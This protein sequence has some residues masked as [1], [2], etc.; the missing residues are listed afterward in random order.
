MR[1]P[2]SI[3]ASSLWHGCLLTALLSW[4][5]VV[6]IAR[7]DPEEEEEAGPFQAFFKEDPA[8]NA[9]PVIPADEY[10]QVATALTASPEHGYRWDLWALQP[11]GKPI[12]R[13]APSGKLANR[14][15]IELESGETIGFIDCTNAPTTVTLINRYGRRI[16]LDLCMNLPGELEV[17]T[18]Y[19]LYRVQER[20]RLG[21]PLSVDTN[22]IGWIDEFQGMLLDHQNQPIARLEPVRMTEIGART[23]LHNVVFDGQSLTTEL[24]TGPPSNDLLRKIEERAA[25]IKNYNDLPTKLLRVELAARWLHAGA[26]LVNDRKATITLPP[27]RILSARDALAAASINELNSLWKEPNRRVIWEALAAAGPLSHFYAEGASIAGLRDDPEVLDHTLRLLKAVWMKGSREKIKVQRQGPFEEW[28]RAGLLDTMR[29]QTARTPEQA[30]ALAAD[31][32][33]VPPSTLARPRALGEPPVVNAY[34]L[35]ILRAANQVSA[36]DGAIHL[37][38]AL[39]RGGRDVTLWSVSVERII[40]DATKTAVQE[41]L[42]VF[43]KKEGKPEILVIGGDGLLSSLKG[44]KIESGYY[45]FP[46]LS[47]LQPLL[48][49]SAQFQVP[50]VRVLDADASLA[51]WT[52]SIQKSLGAIRP[53]DPILTSILFERAGADPWEKFNA[54]ANESFATL[55]QSRF[56][57]FIRQNKIQLAVERVRDGKI[58]ATLKVPNI[59]SRA[60]DEI[61]PKHE[62][63]LGR[64]FQMLPPKF[65]DRFE[66][67]TL[68]SE[69]ILEPLPEAVVE[70]GKI[71]IQTRDRNVI[72]RSGNNRIML[73][74]PRFPEAFH[75][76]MHRWG[77]SR[78][79][80]Y[81]IG[82]W[83]GTVVELFNEI[84]WQ[85]PEKGPGWERRSDDFK[86]ED[87]WWDYGA[88]NERE[89]W[90]V[91]GQ[92]YG[93]L[94]GV[95]RSKVRAA[96]RDGNFVPAAKYLFF[97]YITFL[98]SDG[99]SI[100]IDV[101]EA[102]KPFTMAEFERAV[103]TLEKRGPLNSEQIR[104]RDLVKRIKT[105]NE[106][107]RSKKATGSI[108][109]LRERPSVDRNK[110]TTRDVVAS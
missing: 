50:M 102:D 109:P 84:S 91:I 25:A 79:G 47:A 72:G 12:G 26:A 80:K 31:V 35:G 66:L 15:V 105:L 98:D 65:A 106:M 14:R 52:G 43:A 92:F 100:E 104:M 97:K 88:T 107:L 40:D 33:V 10:Y 78:T 75:E 103:R 76:M 13:M 81:E 16:N 38:A 70:D 36:M 63:V 62:A 30:L 58:V 9:I 59:D 89:D 54:R 46:A 74:A 11:D 7:A 45:E 68:R 41:P 48:A 34:P 95:T 49:R 6:S 22:A 23:N 60:A 37:A 57:E 82:E 19:P 64:C 3:R 8:L 96:L 39:Q 4:I 24:M 108:A 90:A 29:F 17:R 77:N 56:V 61:L 51:A 2:S 83:K 69:P 94:A 20:D 32:K 53:D 28:M 93:T 67:V 101:D 85:R 110:A 55:A 5:G 27:E 71:K 18:P 21:G 86:I 42:I 44:K 99:R 1:T 73:A 87:F